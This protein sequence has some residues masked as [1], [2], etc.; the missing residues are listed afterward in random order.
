[1]LGE[2]ERHD[3]GENSWIDLLADFLSSQRGVEAIRLDTGSR[4]VELA[5][6]GPVDLA[7]LQIQLNEVL[8]RLDAGLPVTLAGDHATG[9]K[10]SHQ[11]GRVVL[12]KPACPTAPRFWKWREFEWPEAEQMEQQSAE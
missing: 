6:L 2:M 10:V 8:S 1:M 5:T 12:E 7:G 11:E 9:L 3:A 4:Q